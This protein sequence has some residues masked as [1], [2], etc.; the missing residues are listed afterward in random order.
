M[1]LFYNAPEPNQRQWEGTEHQCVN[2]LGV[3]L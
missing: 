3:N 2:H 1:G